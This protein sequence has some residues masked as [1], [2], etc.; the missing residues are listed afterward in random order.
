MV[1]HGQRDRPSNGEQNTMGTR[2][3]LTIFAAGPALI[4]GAFAGTAWAG[5]GLSTP[6]GLHDSVTPA[7]YHDSVTPAGY[8]D[9]VAP[10]GH[11]DGGVAPA[12]HDWIG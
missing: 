2:R 12:G 11:V 7:G 5:G 6:A 3:A 9:S 10:A 1:W 4:A 8:H